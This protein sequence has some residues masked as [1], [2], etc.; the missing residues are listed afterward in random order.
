MTGKRKRYTAEFKAKVALEA[1]RGELTAAQLAAKHGI[2]Q[3]MVGNGSGR[4]WRDWPRCSPAKPRRRRRRR[5]TRWRSCTPRSASWWWSGIF[6]P[7]RPVDEQRAET[8]DGRARAPAAV[9]RAAVPAGFDQP[10][11]V[12]PPPRRRDG[13]EPG[14]DAADRR[15]VPGDALVRLAADG[16]A[17]AAGRLRGRPQADATADGEDGPGADPPAPTHDG[18]APR[19][20]GLSLP[21]AGPRRRAAEPGLV[22]RHHLPADAARLPLP[23]RGDGLGDA[24]GAVLA[25]VE[26]P[27]GGVLPRGAGRGPGTVRAAGDLQYRPGQPVHLAAV[28]G[29]AAAGRGAHLDGRPRPLDGQ[30]VHR[31]AVAQSEVRVRLPACLRNRLGAAGRAGEVDRLLQCRT[32][33]Q[34]PGGADPRRGVRAGADGEIGGLTET[35]TEL[36]QAVKLS[37]GWGPPQID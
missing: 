25:G 31:A 7:R 30:R 22:R 4:P 27:G 17:S 24:Q 15:A 32:P 23:G 9:D 14:A 37:D 33:T 19:A 6:W 18:A 1:L 12:L 11:G 26:H 28:H 36:I 5:R 8:A 20:S 2:H 13:A 16:A 35:R 34:R 29:L 21:A 10:I 3:T